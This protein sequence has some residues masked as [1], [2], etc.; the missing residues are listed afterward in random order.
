MRFANN[1]SFVLV[2][3]LV[4]GLVVAC[5]A[6]APATSQAPTA[7]AAPVVVA[8]APASAPTASPAAIAKPTPTP[9]PPTDGEGPE[10]VTGTQGFS[11]IVRGTATTVGE[12][13]QLRGNEVDTIDTMNDPRVTGTGTVRGNADLYGSVGP[14]WGTY[15]LENA[16]GAWATGAGPHPGR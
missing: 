11:R 10:R 5:G 12:A 16:D 8:S 13:V 15:R 9:V 7:T 14:Q 3:V 2:L 4:G 6:T 1:P